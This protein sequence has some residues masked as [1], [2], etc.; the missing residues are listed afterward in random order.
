MEQGRGADN[1]T[2]RGEGVRLA[3]QRL[4]QWSRSGTYVMPSALKCEAGEGRGPQIP[5]GSPTPTHG[6]PKVVG[7]APRA[8]REGPRA[9]P[10]SEGF[11]WPFLRP[12]LGGNNRTFGCCPETLPAG[13]TGSRPFSLGSS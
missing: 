5:V 7:I 11:L 1:A 13:G 4:T 6:S 10:G 12:G 2:A 9:A 3:G 8:Q